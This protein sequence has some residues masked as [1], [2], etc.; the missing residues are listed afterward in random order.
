MTT[1]DNEYKS[2]QAQHMTSDRDVSELIGLKTFQGM[3]DVEIQK[4]ID[5]H[6]NQARFD[7]ASK[8]T[9]ATII[10]QSN[11]AC[12]AYAKVQEESNDILKQVLAQ[13]LKL[14]K[15]GVDG[16]PNGGDA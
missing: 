2:Q 16:Y 1:E 5:W 15:I 8:A 11:E 9:I 10:Q 12:E 7:D 6:V 4:V 14:G 3:S 13:P